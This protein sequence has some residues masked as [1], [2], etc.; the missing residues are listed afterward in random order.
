MAIGVISLARLQPLPCGNI[1]EDVYKTQRHAS[2]ARGSARVAC[3]RLLALWA[4]ARA[5]SHDH[6]R[7]RQFSAEGKIKITDATPATSGCAAR[8]LVAAP[9]PT[10]PT[11]MSSALK[12]IPMP[13]KARLGGD[14]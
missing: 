12:R 4:K 8:P 5:R 6:F 2:G 7:S 14:L 10:T 1:F 11:T 9:S 13:A 3:K